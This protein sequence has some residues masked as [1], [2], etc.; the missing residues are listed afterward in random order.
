M[1]IGIIGLAGAGK[2]TLGEILVQQMP[3]YRLEKFAKPLKDAARIV[4]GDNFDDRDQKDVRRYMGD[5][6]VGDD[7]DKAL[8]LLEDALNLSPSEFD[9]VSRLHEDHLDYEIF[10]SPRE[11]QKDIGDIVREVRP[12]AFV[13]RIRDE[14]NLI[15]TDARFDNELEIADRIILVMRKGIEVNVEH[16]SE[17][18]AFRMTADWNERNFDYLPKG[19][20]AVHNN[21]SIDFLRERSRLIAHAIKKDCGLHSLPDD[22]DCSLED[23]LKGK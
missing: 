13:D 9:E 17:H 23:L 20:L 16:E 19:L 8:L 14:E 12:S 4:F 7:M 11:Y 22:E 15:I 3:G 18:I 6:H 1:R 5:E 21:E 10:L 2:D